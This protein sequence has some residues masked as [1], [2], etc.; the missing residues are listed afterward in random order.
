MRSSGAVARTPTIG[1][2]N[3][4]AKAQKKPERLL[5]IR[6]SNSRGPLFFAGQKKGPAASYSRMGGSHTTLG[7]GALDCRVRNGNGYGNSSMAT[8][9]KP[10]SR[11]LK[12]TTAPHGKSEGSSLVK[13]KKA[14]P[15]VRLVP[16]SSTDRSAC[17]LGLSRSSSTTGLQG[18]ASGRTCLGGGLALR[19]L[20]R[21]S[22]PGIATRPA[23]GATAGTPWARDSRSSRTRESSPQFS[24]AH[25]G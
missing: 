3:N 13:S 4:N 6:A 23:A 2:H 12:R 16:I 20:Q 14:K 22:V 17:T 10:E 21:L 1:V 8:G 11:G 15:H 19:C 5:A 9:E 24:C 7:D 18:L 25:R